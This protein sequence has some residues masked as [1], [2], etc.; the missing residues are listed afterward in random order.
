L[1]S[2]KVATLEDVVIPLSA[3]SNRMTKSI[4]SP[5]LPAWMRVF[6]INLHHDTYQY[7]SWQFCGGVY[8]TF[9]SLS[10]VVPVNT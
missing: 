9:Y 6:N 3:H 5:A 4:G 10:H 7:F 2:H 8:E 1:Y